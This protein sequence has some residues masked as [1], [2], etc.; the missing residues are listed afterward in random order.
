MNADLKQ[1]WQDQHRNKDTPWHQVS[2][3]QALKDNF[4]SLPKGRVFVPLAGK[5]LAMLH[6]ASVHLIAAT[7]ACKRTDELT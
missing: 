7:A 3:E 1:Y 5:S 4:A 2:V 6:L